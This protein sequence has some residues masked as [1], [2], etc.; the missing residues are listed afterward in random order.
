M[1]RRTFLAGAAGIASV[2][3]AALTAD[4]APVS[5]LKEELD[6]IAERFQGALGYSLHNARTGD[7]IDRLGDELFPTASTI[8]LAIMCT[9]F[10]KQQKG[11]IG[12]YDRREIT[13][14]DRRGG[15]GFLQFYKPDSKVELKELLHFMITV[16]DNTATAMLIRWLTAM[17]VNRWLESHGLKST[18]LLSQLPEGETALRE[19]S[20]TW[21]LGVTTPNEMRTLME[22]TVEGRAGTP[23]ATDE[24]HRLLNHQYFDDGIA[25]Q[26]PPDVCVGSKSGALDE[27]RSDVAVVHAPAGTYSLTVYTKDAKDQRWIWEN[28]GMESIRAIS[29]AVFRHYNPKVKWTPPPGVERF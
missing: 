11:E 20:K 2:A 29:R 6:R 3:G 16:S 23:A 10:D 5:K 18:R 17:D 28:Q 27:S 19:L 15:S 12:Y 26:V 13:T 7:R 14:A 24:M 21:G 1:D 4:A 25:G 8:K 9:A 22:M